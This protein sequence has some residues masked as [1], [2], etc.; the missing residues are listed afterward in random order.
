VQHDDAITA[1]GGKFRHMVRVETFLNDGTRMERTVESA[2]GS[3]HKFASASDIVEKFEKLA[4]KALPKSQVAE[5][6]DAMLGLEK[7]KDA[8]ALARLLAKRPATRK[9]AAAKAPSRRATKRR[10]AQRR[11]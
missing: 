7:L 2:R 9:K 6:R 11:K 8:S 3:E 5:L 1:K 4:A 10:P